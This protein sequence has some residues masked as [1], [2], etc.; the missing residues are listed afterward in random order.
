MGAFILTV[1][2]GLGAAGASALW[3]QS[4]TAT[5]TVTAAATWPPKPFTAFTCS[6]DSP[7]KTATLTATTTGTPALLSYAALQPNGTYGPSYVDNVTLGTTSTVTLTIATPMILANRTANQL[8]IRVTATYADLTQTT[9]TAVVQLEQG[10][11][12]NKV[13]CISAV[14]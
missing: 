2:M 7:Q 1:V 4:A 11:N 12:S 14:S 9:G 13:T 6:N 5:M 8:T 10:N 3:Q